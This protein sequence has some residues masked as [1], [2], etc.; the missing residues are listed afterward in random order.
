MNDLGIGTEREHVDAAI[1]MRGVSRQD[2]RGQRLL[3]GVNLSI[4]RGA[5]TT[6]AGPSGAGKTTL[7]RLI[8][9]LDDADGGSVSVLGKALAQWNVGELRR[10]VALVAQE[11]S[12]LGMTVRENLTLPFRLRG[13]LPDNMPERMEL[14]LEAA[15]LEPELLDERSATLSVG[16]KQRAALARA[17]ISEPEVLLLDEPTAGQDPRTAERMMEKLHRLNLEK[18][19]TVLMVSHRLETLRQYGGRLAV[20]IGGRLHGEGDAAEMLARPPTPEAGAFLK[21]G[22][23]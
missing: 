5:F 14:A 4:L 16:Q 23:G 8:N 21:P 18:G 10:R 13:E 12:L 3:D 1:E 2:H 20:L 15:Q 22:G 6:L 7:L 11:P 19:I 17:L 9:R